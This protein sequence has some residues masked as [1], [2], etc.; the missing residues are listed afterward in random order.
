MKTKIKKDESFGSILLGNPITTTLENRVFNAITLLVSLTGLLTMVQNVVADN[1]SVHNIFSIIATLAS[2]TAYIL[3]LRGKRYKQLAVPVFLFFL[4]LLTVSWFATSGSLGTAAY[5]FFILFVSGILLFKK[6]NNILFLGLTLV[7]IGLLLLVEYFNPSLAL[8]YPDRHQR[9]LDVGI[10]LLLCLL[11]T[12]MLVHL[13]A[14]EQQ[15]ERARNERLF[16]QTLKD[17]E[18]LERALREI[19]ILKGFLPICANCKKIRDDRGYWHQVESYIM[20][21]SEAEFSHG[22]C[23]ECKEKLYPELF[24]DAK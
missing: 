17:K 24:D 22:I 7:V 15:R 20:A 16:Q 13:V 3:S 14:A 23:P 21:H 2:T 1:P 4:G 8:P 6:P 10:S 18:E 12:G 11:S 9:L 19:R 5:F